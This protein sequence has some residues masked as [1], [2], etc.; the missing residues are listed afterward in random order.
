[1]CVCSHVY[2]LMAKVCIHG[3]AH[4]AVQLAQDIALCR[5]T[6]ILLLFVGCMHVL[7]FASICVHVCK[8]YFVCV[9]VHMRSC[10][11]VYVFVFM[12]VRMYVCMYVCM[13]VCVYVS[14]CNVYVIL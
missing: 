5:G 6:L 8:C 9:N 3:R 10:I 1:M 13:H 14:R 4:L 11:S 7:M 2:V 12:Y